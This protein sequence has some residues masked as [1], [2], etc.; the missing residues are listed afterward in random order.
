[1]EYKYVLGI[2]LLA[3]AGFIAWKVLKEDEETATAK[4]KADPYAGTIYQGMTADEAQAYYER[5]VAERAA[6][7]AEALEEARLYIENPE[8]AE[9]KQLDELRITRAELPTY[10][11]FALRINEELGGSYVA[12]YLTPP[13]SWTK[14]VT[15]WSRHVQAITNVRWHQIYG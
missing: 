5:L 13:A 15:E 2:G 1:M 6:K 8:A 11:E 7:R 3:A 10:Q 9:Q 4:A 12:G 14:S